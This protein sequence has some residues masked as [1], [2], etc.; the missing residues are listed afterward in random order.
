MVYEDEIR[1][2][3][4]ENRELLKSLGILNLRQDLQVKECPDSSKSHKRH[5]KKVPEPL[6]MRLRKVSKSHKMQLRNV[7]KSEQTLKTSDSS[8]TS[9]EL[10]KKVS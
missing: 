6:T 10:L 2:R 3:R 7:S 1:K 8:I 5:P 4:E 9:R